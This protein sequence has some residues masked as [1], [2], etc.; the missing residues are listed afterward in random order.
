[1][2][3]TLRSARNRAGS[4]PV[5][6]L[7]ICSGITLAA[8]GRLREENSPREERRYGEAERPDSGWREGHGLTGLGSRRNPQ[9]PSARSDAVY[10]CPRSV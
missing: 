10:R 4:H 1:M 2:L 6:R 8:L 9:S 5:I 7:T 3:G